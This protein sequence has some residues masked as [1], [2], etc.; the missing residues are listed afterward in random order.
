MKPISRKTEDEIRYNVMRS[1][2][3][4]CVLQLGTTYLDIFH[5]CWTQLSFKDNYFEIIKR[6]I[7]QVLI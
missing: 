4:G 5:L 7:L 1:L 6:G 2:R 3:A